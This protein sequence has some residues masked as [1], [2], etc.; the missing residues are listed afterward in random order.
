MAEGDGEK[1][2]FEQQLERAV[3]ARAQHFKDQAE[4]VPISFRVFMMNSPVLF[5]GCISSF[6][7]L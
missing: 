6:L 2:A 3:N 4:Y 1:R 5:F 7:M